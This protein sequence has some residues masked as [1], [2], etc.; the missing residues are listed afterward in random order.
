[1]LVVRFYRTVRQR[2]NHEFSTDM[3]LGNRDT[4]SQK[5]QLSHFYTCCATWVYLSDFLCFLASVCLSLCLSVGDFSS[6][7]TLPVCL[8]ACLSLSVCL[9]LRPSLE[10]CV[11]VCIFMCCII[12]IPTHF[13]SSGR[14]QLRGSQIV[15]Q[16]SS[17]VIEFSGLWNGEGM[18]VEWRRGVSECEGE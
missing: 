2:I 4:K 15:S 18:R 6:L 17:S 1:M 14:V 13:S 10:L 16:A 8:T 3:H 5:K 11:C 12:Q 9:F 7:R